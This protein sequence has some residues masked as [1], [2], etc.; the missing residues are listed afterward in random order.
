MLEILTYVLPC[1][2][3]VLSF[4]GAAL[5]A[6]VAH[7]LKCTKPLTECLQED[8]KEIISSSCIVSTPAC[9]DLD[10]TLSK[11]CHRIVD[12]EEKVVALEADMAFILS[13]L[14]QLLNEVKNV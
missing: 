6:L 11:I 5:H 14:K 7:R 4:V 9:A 2:S 13:S 1:L 12:L 10:D 8:K 3:L